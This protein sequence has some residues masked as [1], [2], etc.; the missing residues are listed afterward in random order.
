M[1]TS[2]Y[3]E[4]I[5][6]TACWRTAPQETHQV[7]LAV[8]Q[9]FMNRAKACGIDTYEAAIRWMGDADPEGFPDTRSPHFQNLLNKL[10]SVLS[11]EVSDKTDGALWCVRQ[12][13]LG[14]ISTEAFKITTTIGSIMFLK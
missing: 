4:A 13:Q 11:G 1:T 3:R 2:D 8:C 9:V 6:A 12:D 14:T 10:P 7:M 5:I